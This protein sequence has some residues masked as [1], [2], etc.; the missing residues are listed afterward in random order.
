MQATKERKKT[1]QKRG[2]NGGLRWKV[3]E[4][5]DFF[6]KMCKY[7]MHRVNL[8]QRYANIEV[9]SYM[10]MWMNELN[11]SFIL[12]VKSMSGLLFLYQKDFT[13]ISMLWVCKQ[14]RMDSQVPKLVKPCKIKAYLFQTSSSFSCCYG[15][16]TRTESW[17]TVHE[18]VGRGLFMS[19]YKEFWFLYQLF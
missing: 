11:E 16:K 17:I 13:F 10:N 15:E 3:N 9:H 2:V 12:T 5:V 19:K 1:E 6:L 7:G 14:I 8:C 18:A 4:G